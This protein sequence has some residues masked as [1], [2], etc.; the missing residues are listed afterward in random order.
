MAA[1]TNR[2]YLAGPE[3][4]HPAH[5][6]I[7]DERLA[8]CRTHGLTAVVPLDAGAKTAVEIYRS[9]VARLEASHAVIANITPF[10]GPHGD[11]GTAWEMGYATARGLPVFAFS[12]TAEPLASRVPAGSRPGTDRDGLA[13]EPFGLM[14]NLMI[15]ESLCDRIVHPTFEAAVAAAARLLRPGRRRAGD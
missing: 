1:T 12:A 7:F 10:R 13:V 15:V 14:E 3:V 4:F 2:V 5:A 9:N 6:S 8:I 11:V